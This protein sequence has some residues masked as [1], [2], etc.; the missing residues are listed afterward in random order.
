M[1]LV[2]QLNDWPRS[3]WLAGISKVYTGR[4][5]GRIRDSGAPIG[6]LVYSLSIRRT[7]I[8]VKVSHYTKISGASAVV[9]GIEAINLAGLEVMSLQEYFSLTIITLIADRADVCQAGWALS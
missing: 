2:K 8:L 7:A 1:A 6:A 4:L 9:F 3:S 5:T